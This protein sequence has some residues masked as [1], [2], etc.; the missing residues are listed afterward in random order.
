[1]RVLIVAAFVLLAALAGCA[2]RT[3]AISAKEG[4][5]PARDAARAHGDDPVLVGIMSVE[6]LKHMAGDDYEVW[7]H[8]DKNPGDG[9]APGWLYTFSSGDRMIGVIYA[10]GLGVIA[11]GYEVVDDHEEWDMGWTGLPITDWL[12]DSTE[13][14]RILKGVEGWPAASDDTTVFWALHQEEAGPVWSVEWENATTSMEAAVDARTGNVTQLESHSMDAM[15]ACAMAISPGGS[16]TPLR[17]QSMRIDVME[18]GHLGYGLNWSMTLGEATMTIDGP[19]GRVASDTL[20]NSGQTR[21]SLGDLAGGTY[22]LSVAAD[23]GV[24]EVSMMNMSAC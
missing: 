14:A 3:D 22:T 20:A 21:G 16:V 24:G 5:G 7:V 15:H 1:M 2:D 10:A 13:A 6:P 11:E 18:G 4:L 12:I 9:R 23:L 8:L 17:G 19:E